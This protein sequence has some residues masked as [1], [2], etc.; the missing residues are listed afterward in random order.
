[1]HAHVHMCVHFRTHVQAGLAAYLQTDD[2]AERVLYLQF[3][4]S[5][6]EASTISILCR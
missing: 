2:R 5:P 4:S 3:Q 6:N 1:M